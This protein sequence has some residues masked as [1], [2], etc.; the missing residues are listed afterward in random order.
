MGFPLR[1]ASAAAIVLAF[2]VVSPDPARAAEP[3]TIVIVLTDD[4]R[5]DSL[6]AMPTVQAQLVDR[7]MTFTNAFVSNPLCCPSRTTLLTGK[8]S[9]TTGV[10]TN[11]PPLGGFPAFDDS[12]T[13][14]T[15]LSAAGYRTGFFGKYLNAYSGTYIPPGWDR[16]F[17][18]A[19]G[20]FDYDVNDDGLVRR[21]GSDEADYSTDVTSDKAVS[22]IEETSGPLFIHFSPF[23]PHVAGRWDSKTGWYPIPAARHADLFPDLAPWRPPSFNEDDVFDKPPWIQQLTLTPTL[24]QRLDVLLRKQLQSL[25]AVDEGVERILA[26]LEA[27]GRL[28]NTV[29]VFMSDNGFSLGEHRWVTKS[30]PYEESIRVPLVIRYDPLTSPGSASD[31][32][33]ANVDLAQTLAELAGVEA[34]GA[35]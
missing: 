7:G 29:V 25:Q 35:E 10:W 14:A 26:A 33:V 5:W 6:W 17:A 20:Y 9:H 31:E 16:W 13:L 27:T 24:I 30:L 22:F 19:R 18:F 3:P 8:Y 2:V 1:L 11:E 15:W 21:F 28:D 4:Q 23:A 12:A 34:P 32:L